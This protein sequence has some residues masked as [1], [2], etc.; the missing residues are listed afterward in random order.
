MLL[1]IV[2]AFDEE[3]QATTF[4]RRTAICS[5]AYRLLTEKA[6]FQPEEI[7]FDPNILTIATG[8]E[9]H[10]DYGVDFIRTVRWI[11]ENLPGTLV[12]GGVSN[13]SLLFRA[14]TWSE[15]PCIPCSCIMPLQQ[16]WTW[17]LSMPG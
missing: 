9:E 15:R 16:V 8:M 2:M 3:G 17:A 5:R 13:I 10:N 7:V 12:S 1:V 4:E 11:K 6:G 14:M